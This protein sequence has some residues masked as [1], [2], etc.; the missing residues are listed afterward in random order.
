MCDLVRLP[1]KDNILNN[2]Q[3]KYVIY[4]YDIMCNIFSI[5]DTLVK[6]G[7]VILFLQ[8]C[9]A[10]LYCLPFLLRYAVLSPLPLTDS[11]R[12]CVSRQ[13]GH[14]AFTHTIKLL[15]VHI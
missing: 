12:L 5:S 2:L 13:E 15:P 4:L 9:R 10:M 1:L 8:H 14:Q 7:V 11:F 3:H 6:W